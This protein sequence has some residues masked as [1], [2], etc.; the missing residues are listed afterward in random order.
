MSIFGNETER[1]I[2]LIEQQAKI[3]AP[4]KYTNKKKYKKG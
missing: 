2:K 1:L 4:S 3:E